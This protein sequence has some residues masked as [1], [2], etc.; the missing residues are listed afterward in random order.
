M[1]TIDFNTPK[2]LPLI[3]TLPD[4]ADALAA[5]LAYAAA[6]LYVLPVRSGTKHPGSVVGHCW[7]TKSSRDPAVL[8]AWFAGTDHGVAIDLG[9]SGLVVIDVDRPEDL[10]GWLVTALTESGAPYQSTRPDV[11]GRGH[12]TFRQTEGRA[13]GCGKGKLAG[14]GLDV[15]GA[16]GVIVV[17]PTIH[18]CGGEYRWVVTGEIPALP[19]AIADKLSNGSGDRQ[20]AA[21]D[22]EVRKYIEDNTASTAPG[23][24]KGLIQNWAKHALTD[25]DSRHDAMAELLPWA[26]EE[27]RCGFYS[28]QYA[29]EMLSALFIASFNGETERQRLSPE[30][31]LSEFQGIFA[32]AISQANAHPLADLQRRRGVSEEPAAAG[33]PSGNGKPTANTHTR[34]VRLTWANTIEPEP[35]VWA[36]TGGLQDS[37]QDSKRLESWNLGTL[38]MGDSQDSGRIAAGTIAIV[39]GTEGLGKSSLGVYLAAKVSTGKLSGAW[40]GTPRNTLYVAVEDSWKHTVVPRLLAANANLSRIARFDIVTDTDEAISLSLPHDNNKLEET[41][42]EN[43]IALVVLD[44]LMSLINE[45]LDTHR[46]R[47]V[48]KALDPLVGIADRTGA[49]ILGIA[50][51]NKGSGTDISA[52]IT[53]S[54]AFKN[55][56]RAVFGF[57]RDPE[58]GNCVITQS[59]NSLGRSDLP[60]LAYRIESAEIQTPKGITYTGR[61]VPLGVSDKSVTDILATAGRT[62]NKE[63]GDGLT[64]SQRFVVAYI[65]EHG[66]H[67]GEVTSRD[68]IEAGHSA[69]YVDLVKARTRAKDT[70]ATRRCLD[71]WMWSLTEKYLVSADHLTKITKTP[72]DLQGAKILNGLSLKTPSDLQGAKIP[73]NYTLRANAES[74]RSEAIECV[75][76]GQSLLHP[77]SVERGLC[78]RCTLAEK[79][80]TTV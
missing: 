25:R 16:G 14:C 40:H 23:R 4:E 39:A 46:E 36:W 53:G 37:G 10:P 78:A 17:Q 48:R 50:H 61:F 71:G 69:G 43:D 45:D 20:S 58:S 62:D 11:P 27:V 30:S 73:P 24:I 67:N 75:G 63:A 28:A 51:F 79:G 13:L 72:P 56:P 5:A 77:M 1:T 66:D 74:C 32:W 55:V 35:V 80:P 54:G 41:I 15:R 44:P 33:V 3:P 6:G 38:Q 42:R 7:P 21:T 68:V 26:C 64:P 19:D 76:C 59:K 31:A 60:S 18:P 49:V 34:K 2:A 12:W 65:E 70:I 29:F 52:R 22:A 47:E 9:R 57:A 8:A